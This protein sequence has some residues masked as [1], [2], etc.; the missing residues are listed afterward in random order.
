MSDKMVQAARNHAYGVI[1]GVHGRRNLF[2]GGGY[3]A[4]E[5]FILD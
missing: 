1:E 3:R 4:M 2:G 5:I